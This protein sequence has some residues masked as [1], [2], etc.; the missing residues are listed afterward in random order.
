[1]FDLN[2]SIGLLFYEPD[3]TVTIIGDTSNQALGLESRV[4]IGTNS[5]ASTYVTTMAATKN[6]Q[7]CVMLPVYIKV[8][9]NMTIY[10]I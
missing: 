9:G 10:G 6:S 8:N 5:T 4:F 1:M 3:L 2:A 7:S